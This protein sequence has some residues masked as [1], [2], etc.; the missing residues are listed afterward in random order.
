[1]CSGAVL[2]Y[3][4][5]RLIVG[6]HETFM[7]EEALLS[8]RGVQIEVLHDQHCI[9]LMNSFISNRPQLWNEDIGT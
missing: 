7:G 1:M 5:P 9:A 6:E 3:G 2:L 8:E 4:I